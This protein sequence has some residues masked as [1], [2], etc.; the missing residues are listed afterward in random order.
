MNLRQNKNSFLLTGKAECESCK[1]TGLYQGFAEKD[2]AFVICCVCKGSGSISIA[3]NF[4]KFNGKKKEPKCKRVY[5]QGF[6]Y[7]LTDKDFL[8]E[9]GK[10]FPFSQYGCFYEEWLQ[11][12][13]P[14]PLKFLGCPYQE[15]NQKLRIK[16]VNNL[17]KTRC[18]KKLGWGYIPNCELYD[19]KEECW[20]IFEKSETT[21]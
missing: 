16:D 3:L 2:G 6:G 17:Y 18:E 7:L 8:S 4:N 14:I 5:T 9:D 13:K 19:K 21:K 15:T 12:K 11:G 10:F 20:E 1:G